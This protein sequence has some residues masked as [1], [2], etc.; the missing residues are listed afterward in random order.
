M[1]AKVLE[2]I[3]KVAYGIILGIIYYLVYG[4]ILPVVIL[5]F[6]KVG[7]EAL[8][9]KLLPY[10]V[11]FIALSITEELLKNHPISIPFRMLSKVMYA[12][13]LMIIL[14]GG[15]IAATLSHEPYSVYARIDITILLHMIIALSLIYGVVDALSIVRA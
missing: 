8:T 12:L 9:L 7:L 2:F 15:V 3:K 11:L 4:Y 13:I 14:N 10:L 1:D 6:T 5:S